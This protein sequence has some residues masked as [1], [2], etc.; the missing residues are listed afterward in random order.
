MQFEISKTYFKTHVETQTTKKANV[1]KRTDSY[2]SARSRKTLTVLDEDVH[3]LFGQTVSDDVLVGL[4]HVGAENL[5]VAP[6]SHVDSGLSSVAFQQVAA[7]S[8]SGKHKPGAAQKLINTL[9]LLISFYLS[10]CCQF[11][12]CRCSPSACIHTNRF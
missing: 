8:L 5:L 11:K 2:H 9:M 7:A 10:I 4:H 12:R 6:F 1:E 3:R